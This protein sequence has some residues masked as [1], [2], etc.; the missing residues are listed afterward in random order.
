[1]I[2][3]RAGSTRLRIKNLALIN[4]KPMIYYAIQ[5]AK[6]SGVFDKIVLNSDS[7]LFSKIAERYDV[8]FYQ[9]PENLGGSDI[10]SDDVVADFIRA[11]PGAD[12]IAWV[13]PISPLQTGKE[14]NS[15]IDIFLKENL[16]SLITVNEQQVHCLHNEEPVNFNLNEKF[17][18]TQN[19]NPVQVMV[20]SIMMWKTASFLKA[21]ETKGHAILHGRIGYYPVN[22]LSSIIVKT[23]QDLV[24]ADSLMNLLKSDIENIKYDELVNDL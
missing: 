10:K 14:I 20:Y 18:Q 1:M 23:W 15:I 19:L 12:I 5:A 22:K 11:N 21:M 9:R 2:P 17:E 4:G 7:Q 8:D 3:A 16:N 6:D 13:N 24:L